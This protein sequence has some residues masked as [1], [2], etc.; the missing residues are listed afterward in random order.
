M[1]R[2]INTLFLI[3]LFASTVSAQ[4]KKRVAV[5]DFDY[6][7]VKTN[8]DAVFGT[9][10]DVG[11]GI[12]DLLVTNLVKSGV[13]SVIERQALDKVIAEQNLSNSDRADSATAAK[14][15]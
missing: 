15:A 10:V 6:K 11:K 14:L 12:T 4:A 5:L 2:W 3:V 1:V 13:Y 8:A 7:T 9:T